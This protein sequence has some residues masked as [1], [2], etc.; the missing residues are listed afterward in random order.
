MARTLRQAVAPALA[1]ASV[2][3]LGSAFA[4]ADDMMLRAS[5]LGA[6]KLGPY[7]RGEGTLHGMI[8]RHVD[9]PNFST[10][11]F[12]GADRWDFE[13]EAFLFG[14]GDLGFGRDKE[15]WLKDSWPP[16]AE[17]LFRSGSYPRHGFLAGDWKKREDSKPGGGRTVPESGTLLLVGTGLLGLGAAVKLFRG[18][19]DLHR[20]EAL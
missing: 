4:K 14:F 5:E 15:G 20:G 18:S 2:I 8:F 12:V 3:L 17:G 19:V 6:Q 10:R 16:V 11:L 1:L 9:K 7:H 13:R